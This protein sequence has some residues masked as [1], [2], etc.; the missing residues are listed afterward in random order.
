MA[1]FIV[2][3]KLYLYSQLEERVLG[4]LHDLQDAL[5]MKELLARCVKTN[6]EFSTSPKLFKMFKLVSQRN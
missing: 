5:L 2:W 6:Y 1:L 4:Y 3:V